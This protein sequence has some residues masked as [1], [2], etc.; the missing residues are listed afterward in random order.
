MP[1]ATAKIG[2]GLK[3]GDNLLKG[4]DLT[5]KE[6][7]VFITCV[8]VREAPKGFKSPLIME[9]QEVHSKTDWAINQTNVG[10]LIALIDD[11]Y[12]KWP[13]WEIELSKYLTTNPQTK[14]QAWGLS[15]T[16]AKKLAARKRA[17]GGR[18]AED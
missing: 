17:T 15:V 16:G 14:K 6:H 3:Q 8:G 10:A 11:D 4:S 2:G 5:P 7:K 18:V 9:I 13:G 12:D 1:S